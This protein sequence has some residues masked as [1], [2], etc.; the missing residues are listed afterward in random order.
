MAHHFLFSPFSF[1]N[2]RGITAEHSG[3]PVFKSMADPSLSDSA[4][5]TENSLLD[6]AG[7]AGKQYFRLHECSKPQYFLFHELDWLQPF[8]FR[9]GGWPQYF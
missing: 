7:A 8:W 6:W 5:V 1:V 3:P 2:S 4:R 9:E